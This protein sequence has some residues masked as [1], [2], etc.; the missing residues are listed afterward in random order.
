MIVVRALSATRPKDQRETS[1]PISC[2]LCHNEIKYFA[3]GECGHTVTCAK[4][5]LHVRMLFSDKQCVLCKIQNPEIVITANS[6]LPFEHFIQHRNDYYKDGIDRTI[7]YD[8]SASKREGA[9]FLETGLRIVNTR[10]MSA[11]KLKDK[12]LPSREDADKKTFN[13]VFLNGCSD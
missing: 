3:L 9:K 2:I 13:K 11:S 6:Q 12:K 1:K 5:C 10:Q 4:C 8:S 7:F